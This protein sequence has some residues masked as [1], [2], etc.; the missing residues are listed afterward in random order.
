M[1]MPTHL[2]S[3]APGLKS[4]YSLQKSLYRSVHHKKM[5]VTVDI[6][7]PDFKAN[8]TEALSPVTR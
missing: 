8:S 4:G 3:N 1:P 2:I 7:A 5:N 6:L